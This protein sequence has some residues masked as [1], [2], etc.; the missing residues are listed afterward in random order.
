MA[1]AAHHRQI[2]LQILT[3]AAHVRVEVKEERAAE[4]AHGG[5]QRAQQDQ[6][7]QVA[8]L[9][10]P[11]RARTQRVQLRASAIIRNISLRSRSNS[12]HKRERLLRAASERSIR[13]RDRAE[14]HANEDSSLT[15]M[16]GT[17]PAA[18]AFSLEL[19]KEIRVD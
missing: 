17:S 19:F 14:Q 9:L 1:A 15:S 18:T 12:C 2:S 4:A 13:T 8:L 16:S 7:H 11:G 3:S 6:V 10:R 5:S